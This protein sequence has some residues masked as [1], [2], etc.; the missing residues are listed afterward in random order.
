MATEIVQPE[1]S[2]LS[3]LNHDTVVDFFFGNAR[4]KPS[5]NE[6]AWFIEVCKKRKL[7]PILKDIYLIKYDADKPASWVVGKDALIK[8]ASNHPDFQGMDA[9][10][11]LKRGNEIVHVEGALYFPGDVLLGGWA[12]VYR[13]NLARPISSS[14]AVSEYHS[15]QSTWNK[16]PATMTRKTAL[17]QALREAFPEE[18]GGLYDASEMQQAEQ[19]KNVDLLELTNHE[20][21]PEN[22]QLP[23]GLS[24]SIDESVP[25]ADMMC[26]I[27]QLEWF[28]RGKMREHAHPVEGEV[29]PRGGN[30]WCNQSKVMEDISNRMKDIVRSEEWAPEVIAEWF[31]AWKEMTNEEKFEYLETYQNKDDG[32]ALVEDEDEVTVV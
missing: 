3:S 15:K 6:V 18:F 10:I 28:M 16:M 27:H 14:V 23:E 22:I 20:V 19:Y 26:P 13:K 29:G 30:V 11:V 1:A 25:E 21:V 32:E 9:G 5:A 7:N 12:K 17:S 2:D 4:V 31:I 8:R 24:D